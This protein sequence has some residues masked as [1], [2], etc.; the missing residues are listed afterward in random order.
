MREI[1]YTF[2]RGDK[3]G[4]DAD[5]AIIEPGDSDLVGMVSMF[6]RF[7]LACGFTLPE[8]CVLGWVEDDGAFIIDAI[9][10]VDPDYFDEH[11]MARPS[12]AE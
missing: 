7:L 8:G 6:S 3:D 9:D 11:G 5:V 4:D 1:E 2:M 12:E 10:R